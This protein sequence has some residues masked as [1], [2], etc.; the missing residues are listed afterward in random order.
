M[1]IVN[2]H[3]AKS[4]LS[5]LLAGAE[6]GEPFI[7]ARAGKPIAKVLKLDAHTKPK[8]IG[9]MKPRG[10]IPDDFDTMLRDEIAEAFEGIV[11]RR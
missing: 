11:G 6:R 2:I 3:D 4:N 7:I 10:R 5:K 1:K 9:F 8:R